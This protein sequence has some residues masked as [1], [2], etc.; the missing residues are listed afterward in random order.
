MESRCLLHAIHNLDTECY[1][2]AAE[3]IDWNM[4]FDLIAAADWAFLI[5]TC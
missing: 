1:S 4:S 3:D 5:G 2:L